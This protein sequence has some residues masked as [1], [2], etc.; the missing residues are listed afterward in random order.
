M[1]ILEN[2][3]FTDYLIKYCEKKRITAYELSKITGVS[4]TYCYRLLKGQMK[5]P[6]LKI[7]RLIGV[8]MKL[9]YED[10]LNNTELY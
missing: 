3:Q 8:T 5:N 6:S 1:Q 2:E 9:N 4:Q 10:Y 7:V